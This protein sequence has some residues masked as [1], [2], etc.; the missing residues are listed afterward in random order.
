[1]FHGCRHGGRPSPPHY[2]DLPLPAPLPQPRLQPLPHSLRKP[3][4]GLTASAAMDVLVEPSPHWAPPAKSTRA[5]DMACPPPCA[6]LPDLSC[7]P[8]SSPSRSKFAGVALLHRRCLRLS[9]RRQVHVAAL[10]PLLRAGRDYASLLLALTAPWPNY[11]HA[12]PARSR[13]PAAPGLLLPPTGPSPSVST[14]PSTVG[15]ASFDP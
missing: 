1:M 9:R 5:S 14:T 13:G 7:S 15:P 3:R 12:S 11:F 4:R 2:D 8:S 10:L 6:A